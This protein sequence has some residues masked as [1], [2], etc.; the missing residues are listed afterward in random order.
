MSDTRTAVRGA[1][2]RGWSF[3]VGGSIVFH[4]GLVIAATLLP[5]GP[6]EGGATAHDKLFTPGAVVPV[7]MMPQAIARAEPSGEPSLPDHRDPDVPATAPLDRPR[8]NSPTP[9]SGAEPPPAPTQAESEPSEVPGLS[10]HGM[11][12]GARASTTGSGV[13]VDPSL[14]QGSR[15]AYEDSVKNPGVGEGA[16]QGPAAPPSSAVDYAFKREKGKLVYRDPSGRFVATL[17]S[18]GRVDFRNKG[19]KASW[20]QIGLGGPGDLLAAAGGDDPYARIKAKL[21]KATFEMRLGM[22]VQFQTKQLDK[23]LRRLNGELDK[24]WA[25][26]RRQLGARKELL[27]QRWDECDEP[28]DVA[29]PTSAL[30]GFGEVESSDLDQA[31]QDAASSAR[32]LI[33]KFVREHAPKG[34]PEAFTPAELSDMNRRRVSKQKFKPYG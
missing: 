7:E 19:A 25:D 1:R 11:R 16:V 9:R 24:I 21:L 3:A 31:R 5:D 33:E 32:R 6:R 4:V 26:E 20:T 28:E 15:D 17:R 14:L 18:D 30:P 22:A 10:L 2:T 8:S 29:S 27:F 34:S 12:D 23:R 13:V